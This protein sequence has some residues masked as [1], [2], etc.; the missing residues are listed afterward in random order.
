M[1]RLK[2]LP[3]ILMIVLC[4]GVLAIGVYAAAPTNNSIAGIIKIA[5]A[6]VPV[7]ITIVMNNNFDNP[8]YGPEEVNKTIETVNISNY[9]TYNLASY[10]EKIDIPDTRITILVRNMSDVELGAYF[11]TGTGLDS[12]GYA[13]ANSIE[14]WKE[15]KDNND[16]PDILVDD[17]AFADMYMTS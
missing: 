11:Y 3:S 8:I 17:Y 7:E 15:I 16:T 5:G 2:F 12:N 4:F 6:N 14:V 9:L 13:T 10:Q 1:K